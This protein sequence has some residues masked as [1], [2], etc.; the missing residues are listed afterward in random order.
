V[1]ACR[2]KFLEYP[3]LDYRKRVVSIV[4]EGTHGYPVSSTCSASWRDP[5][6]IL[7][8]GYINA[9]LHS[10]YRI[11]EIID[12]DR[13]V[14]GEGNR[15]CGAILVQQTAAFVFVESW[16]YECGVGVEVLRG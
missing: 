14:C 6:A 8:V 16:G 4:Y 9:G 11:P 1:E 2:T 5:L 12:D 13:V 3:S 10:E 7:S 15:R